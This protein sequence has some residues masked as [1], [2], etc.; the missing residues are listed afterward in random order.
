MRALLEFLQVVVYLLMLPAVAVLFLVA[1]TVVSIADLVLRLRT[2]ADTPRVFVITGA[3][4]GIGEGLALHYAGKGTT[5]CLTDKHEERLK[6]VADACVSRRVCDQTC[7]VSVY[8]FRTRRGATVKTASLDVTD[9]A[10][11]EAW[12]HAIDNDTPVDVV[13]ANAVR[14]HA[15]SSLADARFVVTT[16]SLPAS[17][18]ICNDGSDAAGAARAVFAVNVDGVVNTVLPLLPAMRARGRGR[19]AIMSSLASSAP[20]TRFP[21]YSASK[22]AVRAYGEALR[23]AVYRDGVRV[24]VVCPG[25]VVS[26][27]TR[28]TVAAGTVL[29]GLMA[30]NAAVA[31]IAD[32]LARD[33]PVV[34]FPFWLHT[35]F[36]SAGRVAPPQLFHACAR[37]QRAFHGVN[38]LRAGE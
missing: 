33:V 21:V 35:V 16:D 28:A 3:A 31:R 12:L 37:R 17:Q 20:L 6:L 34:Q 2:P 11:M 19:I 18:G 10:S 32:G 4:G 14:F 7:L 25:Y 5:L 22:A 15:P 29:P 24:N 38:Y 9:A 26:N 36:A 13:I 8:T 23:G 27:M 30:T 1:H